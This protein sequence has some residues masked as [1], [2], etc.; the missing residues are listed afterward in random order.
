M[1]AVATA[2]LHERMPQ[3]VVRPAGA[4]PWPGVVVIT[5]PAA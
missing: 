2:T 5:L 3:H 1:T 4:G